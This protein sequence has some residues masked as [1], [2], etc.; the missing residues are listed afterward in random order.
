MK[1]K[2]VYAIMFIVILSS[3]MLFGRETMTNFKVGNINEGLAGLTGIISCYVGIKT[4]DIF[5]CRMPK[6]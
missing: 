4:A 2:I 3:F 1:W 6:P 5:F